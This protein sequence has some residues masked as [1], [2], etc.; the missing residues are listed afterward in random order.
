MLVC[1]ECSRFFINVLEIKDHL[2]YLHNYSHINFSK[3]VCPHSSCQTE[4][5][6]W[7]G[8]IKHFKTFHEI[9]SNQ[10][11][12]P[13]PNNNPVIV[14]NVEAGNDDYEDLSTF[15]TI[16]LELGVKLITDLLG[17]FTSSLLCSGVNN[18]TVDFVI[19][20]LEYSTREIFN[21]IIKIASQSFESDVS[22][23]SS[24][25]LGLLSSFKNVKSS[26]QRQKLFKK[27]NKLILPNEISLGTR[28]EMRTRE[29]K[30]QQVIVSDTFMYVPLLKTLESMLSSSE[31]IK[32]FGDKN[33][34]TSQE[35][36]YK[37]YKDGNSFK[38]NSLFS[39]TSN[40][41]QIQLFYDD[42]ETVNPLGSKRGIHKI[43][44]V[45]FILRNLPDFFNSQLSNIKL[46]ALFYSEDSK[47]YGYNSIFK[48]L[49][50]DIK[51]LENNGIIVNGL[52][53]IF[54]TICSIVHDNLGAN[55]LFGFQESFNA[56]YYCRICCT[57]KEDAQSEFDH[58]K[59]LIRN[60]QNYGEHLTNKTFGVQNPCILNE[61]K[62]FNFLD[63]PTVDIMHDVLEGV[64]PYELKLVL[65]K[66]IDLKCFTLEQINQRILSHDYGTL[67]SKNRPCPIRLDNVGNRI[68][69]KAAQA[70][71]LI[72]FLPI[73]L[74]DLIQTEDQLKFWELILK[75]LE[76]MSYIFCRNF[77]EATIISLKT[78][79]IKHH[80]LFKQLFPEKKLIPKHHFMCHYPY[81]IRQ[82]GPLISL[83]TMRFEGK[84]NYFVQLANQT[85][86]FKNICYTL[87]MR[88]QQYSYDYSKND[89]TYDILKTDIIYE[90]KLSNFSESYDVIECLRM[91]NGFE[92][93]DSDTKVFTTNQIWY[94]GYNYRQEFVVC[95][96]ISSVFPRFGII[97]EFLLIDENSCLLI[98]RE[99]KVEHFD[100][101][102]FAYKVSPI[103]DN[104]KL[105]NVEKLQVHE[106]MEIQQNCKLNGLFI[107]CRH[108]L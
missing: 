35:G 87:A 40:S 94:R 72:R 41:F 38:N 70:W 10:A 13:T 67:E 66:L 14:N 39:K 76:C 61:L 108:H 3:I 62:Y 65:Q 1:P 46:L 80:Y 99:L 104:I 28:I 6:T 107:V 17:N 25:I 34:Y 32:Y 79:V 97:L 26:Y 29:N 49:L 2:K 23:F 53:R 50:D 51:Q 54:G 103:E 89:I 77:S 11:L 12:L 84:H 83:W 55:S 52:D 16:S 42:F 91:F 57:S 78:S 100:R 22:T 64:V 37:C 105:V 59:M 9:T 4:I 24:K 98:I 75:L 48:H 68:G 101:H 5:S 60:R 85:R 36:I 43:G 58:S 47:K 44:A 7:S 82:S 69:Q 31:V 30:R 19:K 96:E 15:E 86:N 71:C 21:I 45:Y 18:T 81:I 63:S 56:H 106:C 33:E 27:S 92:Q 73:I 74:G 20:E 90:M 102:L 95:F 88:H 8:L 93:C